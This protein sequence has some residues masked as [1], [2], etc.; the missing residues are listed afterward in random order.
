MFATKEYLTR[1]YTM[2]EN[3]TDIR[4]SISWQPDLVNI[5]IYNYEDIEHDLEIINVYLDLGI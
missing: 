2:A 3:K 4:H 1:N 5:K